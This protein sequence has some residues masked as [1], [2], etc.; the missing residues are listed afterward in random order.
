MHLTM[1]WIFF[2]RKIYYE[3]EQNS[4]EMLKP[5]RSWPFYLVMLGLIASISALFLQYSYYAYEKIP[6]VVSSSLVEMKA[7]PTIVFVAI[8]LTVASV[9]QIVMFIRII[10]KYCCSKGDDSEQLLWRHKNYLTYYPFFFIIFLLFFGFGGAMPYN[11]EGAWILY[12][13]SFLN[14]FI[15]ILQFLYYVPS[16][17]LN[18]PQIT[19]PQNLQLA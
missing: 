5:A 15:F 14:I 13:Y 4:S 7:I 9:Y 8:F 10:K 12:G 18:Q 2:L 1:L 3:P 16:T 17:E 11:Y 6:I 19:N